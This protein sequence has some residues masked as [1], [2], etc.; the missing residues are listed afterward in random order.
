MAA[1]RSLSQAVSRGMLTGSGAGTASAPM[2]GQGH[3]LS[4]TVQQPHLVKLSDCALPRLLKHSWLIVP[5][6]AT[7]QSGQC[8][9]LLCAQKQPT[10]AG[11]VHAGQAAAACIVQDSLHSGQT[12]DASASITEDGL[13]PGHAAAATACNV[14]GSLHSCERCCDLP[15]LC[16]THHLFWLL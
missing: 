10:P 12:L 13:R 5:A 6:L 11:M 15:A 16:R 7:G 4:L 1:C 9:C 2:L 8:S 3:A 14:Q